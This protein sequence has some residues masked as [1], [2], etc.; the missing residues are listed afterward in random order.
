MQ[1]VLLSKTMNFL[2]L[3]DL[4]CGPLTELLHIEEALTPLHV[5]MLLP[6]CAVAH[7]RHGL[8]I[9]IQLISTETKSNWI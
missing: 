8:V 4:L 2:H 5:K 3:T 6:V 9:E 7:E 1:E